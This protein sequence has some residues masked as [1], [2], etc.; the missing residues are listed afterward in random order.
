MT[1]V[2]CMSCTL[3]MAGEISEK[4]HCGIRP[5]VLGDWVVRRQYESSPCSSQSLR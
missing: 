1:A 5:V 4:F 3:V 2:L